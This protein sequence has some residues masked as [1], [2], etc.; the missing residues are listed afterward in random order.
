MAVGSPACEYRNCVY[1]KCRTIGC[2][3]LVRTVEKT[4][5]GSEATRLVTHP[6]AEC[7][8]SGQVRCGSPLASAA[9]GL[10]S[11]CSPGDTLV[12]RALSAACV[13]AVSTHC[14][15]P[16]CVAA[17]LLGSAEAS[18]NHARPTKRPF[19]TLGLH[20]DALA[21]V[22]FARGAGSQPAVRYGNRTR[23]SQIQQSG[24]LPTELTL[25]RSRAPS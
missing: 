11:I 5:S 19:A 24:A 6:I 7:C 23:D 8:L 20:G 17:T 14:I 22:P 16:V 21:S 15:A 3:L 10:A 9:A 18:R 4:P 2:L 13:K 25:W 12:P 1:R